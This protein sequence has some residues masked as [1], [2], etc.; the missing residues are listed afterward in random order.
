MVAKGLLIC[1]KMVGN[2]CGVGVIESA[3]CRA[4][5]VMYWCL[6]L[7]CLSCFSSAAH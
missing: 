1:G 5:R 4:V 2:E 6:C 7:T 3:V